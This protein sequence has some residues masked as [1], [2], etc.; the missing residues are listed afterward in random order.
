MPVMLSVVVIFV[1]SLV[2]ICIHIHLNFYFIISNNTELLYNNN[3]KLF[4][5]AQGLQ[6][7]NLGKLYK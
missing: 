3:F 4:F 2:L 1:R 5:A 7:G 6:Q